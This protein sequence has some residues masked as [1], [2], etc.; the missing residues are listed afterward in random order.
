MPRQQAILKELL[1]RFKGASS[2]LLS[3]EEVRKTLKLSGSAERG[4]KDIPL[5]AIVGSVGRYQDFTRDFL[6]RFE[7]D[8]DRWARVKVMATGLVGLPPI[9]V[10]QIGDVYF[11]K[12]G[13]HR[14]SVARQMGA[15]HIQA[16]VTEV[17][18]RVP[19]TTELQPDDLIMKA[20]Y[21]DFLE[22]TQLDILRPGSDLSIT[23]PGRYQVLLDQIDVH[24]YYLGIDLQ[25]DITYLEAVG[26]WYDTVYLPVVQT[27][28]TLGILRNFPGRTE[29][30]LYVW[31]VEHR[32]DLEGALGWEIQPEYAAS[33]LGQRQSAK[34]KSVVDRIGKKIL[35][36]ITPETL[37]SG[38]PP[39]EWRTTTQ[40]ARRYDCLFQDI[41]VPVNGLDEGWNALEQAIVLAKCEDAGLHGLHVVS[42]PEKI[43]QPEI[44]NIKKQFDERCEQARVR[45]ELSIVS[46]QVSEQIC[47]YAA[48]SDL[49]I[50]NLAH[51]P[52]EKPL[53]RLGS[54][55]R[56]LIQRCP[57]PVLAAPNRIS[58]LNKAALAFDGSSKSREGLYIA[59]YLA[60]KWGI[61]LV[62]LTVSDN[63]QGA[64]DISAQAREYLELQEITASYQV[65]SGPVADAIMKAAKS[66]ECDFYIMGG[67]GLNP[68]LEVVLGSTVDRV[69][70]E[71]NNPILIC[72]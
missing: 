55:F 6:P 27:I 1:G 30:D 53:D 11:V 54:G 52:G 23:T 5:D 59:S 67:Y 68:V 18:S 46:G 25:R 39:G 22:R 42:N 2:Q 70:R 29:T 10:Y 34:S 12:D 69:L 33:D 71:S 38:P 64:Q 4:L 7:A 32:S 21:S 37:E 63:G 61:Q 40:A 41:L 56:R 19:V 16:Y 51:P 20:E 43:E 45:G 26:L 72:R 62:V 47:K 31:I 60:G 44:Q 15:S 8:A 24:R 57:R 9:Q 66:H 50:T 17:K 48:W 58:L 13:N 14:V 3:F 49:V 35:S 36:I 28:H 65:T